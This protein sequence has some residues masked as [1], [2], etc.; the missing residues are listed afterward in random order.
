LVVNFFFKLILRKIK[1]CFKLAT[2]NFVLSDTDDND[3][4]GSVNRQVVGADKNGIQTKDG[5]TSHASGFSK[6]KK[7]KKWTQHICI[8][9]STT[10]PSLAPF[11]A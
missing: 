2:Y 4:G 10:F 5:G 3:V 1:G 9:C 6:L 8:S 7:L 11:W